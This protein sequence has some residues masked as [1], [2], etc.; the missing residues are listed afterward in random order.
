MIATISPF[1]IEIS[2]PG[3][4]HDADGPDSNSEDYPRALTRMA[5]ERA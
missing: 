1:S 4:A 2:T 3:P 5:P